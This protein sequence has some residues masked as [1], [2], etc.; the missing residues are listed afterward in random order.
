MLGLKTWS[1]KGQ[2]RLDRLEALNLKLSMRKSF[3]GQ[4]INHMIRTVQG[5]TCFSV[6]RELSIFLELQR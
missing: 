1:A 5:E 3:F 6:K 2:C 4:I